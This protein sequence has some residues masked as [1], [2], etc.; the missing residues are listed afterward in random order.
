MCP[1]PGHRPAWLPFISVT[2]QLWSPPTMPSRTLTQSLC[3][4][5]LG[6]WGEGQRRPLGP[7]PAVLWLLHAGMEASTRLSPSVSPQPGALGRRVI[8]PPPPSAARPLCAGPCGATGEGR[9]Q[10]HGL[11]RQEG[12]S[13]SGCFWWEGTHPGSPGGPALRPTLIPDTRQTPEECATS[14]ESRCAQP[15]G[16]CQAD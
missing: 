11:S 2:F 5:P 7:G 15:A 8:L 12:V 4:L 9:S 16:W 6:G 1:G 10:A 13:I 3:R 14:C